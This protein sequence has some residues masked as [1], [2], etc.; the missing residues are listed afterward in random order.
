MEKQFQVDLCIAWT[1]NS[2]IHTLGEVNGFSIPFILN[3]EWLRIL[4]EFER[5]WNTL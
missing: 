4:G 3:Y 2:A 1:L 5:S